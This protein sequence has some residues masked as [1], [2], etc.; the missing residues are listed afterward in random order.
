MVLAQLTRA[1]TEGAPEAGMDAQLGYARS[2]RTEGEDGNVRDGTRPKT[3]LPGVGPV[4]VGMP[5]D[6]AAG[7]GSLLCTRAE[8][9]S[10]G[11]H[12][13]P[14]DKLTTAPNLVPAARPAAPPGAPSWPLH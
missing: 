6:R 13:H 12:Q 10:P 4:E 9:Q 8:R 5:R 3:L 14:P 2:Q 1:G 7:F 11:P